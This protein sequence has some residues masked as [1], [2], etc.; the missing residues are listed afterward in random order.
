MVEIKNRGN[1]MLLYLAIGWDWFELVRILLENGAD[2]NA[3]N[4]FGKTPFCS[5]THCWNAT[6]TENIQLSIPPGYHWSIC[7]CEQM[8]PG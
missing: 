4:K 6:C 3:E 8:R 7:G 1:Q 2:I 5:V